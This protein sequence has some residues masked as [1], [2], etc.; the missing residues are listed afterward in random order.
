MDLHRKNVSDILRGGLE[1]DPFVNCMWKPTVNSYHNCVIS[2][3]A[4]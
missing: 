3:Y 2:R 4:D 1:P